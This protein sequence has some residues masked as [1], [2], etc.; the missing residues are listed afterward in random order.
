M[1]LPGRTRGGLCLFAVDAS[2]RWWDHICMLLPCFWVERG[3]LLCGS[4]SWDG[5]AQSRNMGKDVWATVPPSRWCHSPPQR[6]TQM[7]SE[8]CSCL[9]PG[10]L[11]G[12]QDQLTA[13]RATSLP[14]RCLNVTTRWTSPATAPGGPHPPHP[15]PTR[16]HQDACQVS[17]GN[18]I[19][20]GPH[21]RGTSPAADSMQGGTGRQTRLGA[22]LPFDGQATVAGDSLV[23]RGGVC[24]A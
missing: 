13:H 4:S 11:V 1:E 17:A 8:C 5:G 7:G 14:V 19:H 24:T 9:L 2:L 18:P 12:M 22:A 23:A 21:P 16:C 6:C 15:C 20:A 3:R 10:M